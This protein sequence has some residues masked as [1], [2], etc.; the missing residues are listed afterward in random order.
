MPPSPAAAE[1]HAARLRA[2]VASLAS[3]QKTALE[4]AA[5][6]QVPKATAYAWLE[7]LRKQRLVRRTMIRLPA[8]SQRG[9]RRRY[10]YSAIT[11]CGPSPNA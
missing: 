6:E 4:V 3:Q 9:T 8:S 7:Q 11:A 2:L 5:M 10:V 1:A